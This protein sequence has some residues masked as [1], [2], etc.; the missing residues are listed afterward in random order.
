MPNLPRLNFVV[1]TPD[2]IAADLGGFRWVIVERRTVGTFR[3]TRLEHAALAAVACDKPTPADI[4]AAAAAT[5]IVGDV[6]DLDAAKALAEFDA[7]RRAQS[8]RVARPAAA[9]KVTIRKPKWDADSEEWV[10]A[11]LVDG[12]HH[13]G[14]TYYTNTRLDAYATYN[15]MLLEQ[16]AADL[17]RE[18]RRS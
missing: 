2:T 18:G 7:E 17:Y 16:E 13:E 5:K 12:E 11:V 15:A 3:V 8:R 4:R 9:G 14:R 1:T 6:C 10:V